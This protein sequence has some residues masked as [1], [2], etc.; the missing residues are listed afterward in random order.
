MSVT[1]NTPA[2]PPVWL[3]IAISLLWGS[4]FFA[5]ST[6]MLGFAARL[7]GEGA[8]GPS[9]SQAGTAY[10]IYLP[11]LV[12]V[13][14]AT[15]AVRNRMDPEYRALEK[16]K[17]EVVA[18]RKE[19][20]FVSLASSIATSFLFTLLAASVHAKAAVLT[21]AAIE[22]TPRLVLSG[23]ALNIAAG[24]AVSML[25]GVVIFVLRRLGVVGR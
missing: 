19:R 3:W 16:R 22:L 25:V 12:L 2:R 17:A 4:V 10:L 5:T 9:A 14:L 21:G 24:L 11:M 15:M 13:A 7:T 23:A 6:W 20:Y 1:S 8:F 18:G